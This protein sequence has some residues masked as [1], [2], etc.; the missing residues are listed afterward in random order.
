MAQWWEER[1][2]VAYPRATPRLILA[3]AGG[4]NGHRPRLWKAQLPSQLS[5][6]LGLTVTVCHDPTGGSKWHPIEPRWFSQIRLNWAGQPLRTFDTMLGYL[7]D[8]TTTTGLQVTAQL[9]AGFYQTGQQVTDA[10]MKTLH[11]EPHAVCPHWNYTI[12]PRVD[13]PLVT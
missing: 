1:G 7:C 5:D 11:M 12:R 13:G 2:R 10:V 4:S 6:R 9:L 3:D 8:T